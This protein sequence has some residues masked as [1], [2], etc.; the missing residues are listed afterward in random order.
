MTPNTADGAQR[1]A[2]YAGS[3]D[4][5]TNGHAD[6]IQRALALGDRL[7]VAVATNINKKPLFSIDERMEFIKTV[8]GNNSRIE[9]RAFDGL[10]VNFAKEVGAVINV[11]GVRSVSDF[12]SETQMAIMNR[13][14]LPTLETVFLAP[15]PDTT[16]ISSSL[17]REVARFGGDVSGLVHPSVVDALTK[18]FREPR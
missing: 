10:L 7:V 9:V 4:P 11:R 13:R 2:L 14:L 17:I 12:E 16:F 18:K 1:I 3:F 5:I 8:A 15:S 6:L